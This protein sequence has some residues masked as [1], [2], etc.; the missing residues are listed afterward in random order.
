[1]HNHNISF[2]GAGR[3]ASSLC[4]EIYNKGYTIDLIVSENEKNGKALA[5]SCL[6]EWSSHPLIPSST[7]IVIVAVPDHKLKSVLSSLICIE[8]TLIVHTA[9]SIGLNIF[10]ENIKMKGVFYPLQTFSKNRNINFNEVPFLIESTDS[11]SDEILKGLAE[12]ISL[13]VYFANTEHRR[14]LHLAAVFVNNFTNHML[15]MGGEIALKA[16]FSLDI[17]APLIQETV[18]KALETGPE[19][20]QTGPAVR[21]DKNT[22]EMHLELLSFSPELQKI[23][24]E[25]TDSIIKHHKVSE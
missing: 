5:H 25:L 15:V 24:K 1:M 14:M 13:R 3:V 8:E 2:I 23:Y 11:N 12:S 22:I 7:N 10:P 6:A 16:G 18:S 4:H 21:N 20:S 19:N 9:G 17:L